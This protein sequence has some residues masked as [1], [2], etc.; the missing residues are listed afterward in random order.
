MYQMIGAMV[1]LAISLEMHTANAPY[2]MLL[3]LRLE[4][5]S[6]ASSLTILFCGLLFFAELPNEQAYTIL[7]IIACVVLF[8]SFFVF[9]IAFI[10]QTLHFAKLQLLVYQLEQRGITRRDL[11]DAD[12][13]RQYLSKE[14]LRE[15]LKANQ[16][17][18]FIVLFHI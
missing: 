11:L 7:T 17:T 14:E 18:N 6:L 10:H 16:S 15:I 8:V 13:A 12:F 2:S 3:L 9:A 1:T 5:L 4:Y